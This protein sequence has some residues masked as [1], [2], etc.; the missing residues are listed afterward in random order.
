MALHQPKL[1]SSYC[2]LGLNT[3]K[4]IKYRSAHL[5]IGT[6]VW[7]HIEE[8]WT[9]GETVIAQEGY[10]WLTRWETN[11]PYVITKYFDSS[12]KLVGIYCDINKPVRRNA[13]GFEF[14]DLYL[15]VWQKADE[16]PIILDEDELSEAVSAGFIDTDEANEAKKV[17]EYLVKLLLG[18]EDDLFLF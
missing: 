17:A 2:G 10:T 6:E 1:M 11:K 4:T 9:E 14:D 13:D 3:I 7:G 5:A 15:D 12:N 8:P 16:E 18:P